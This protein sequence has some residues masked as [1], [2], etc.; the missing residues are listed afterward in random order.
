MNRWTEKAHFSQL[1]TEVKNY[2][3]MDKKGDM[4][5]VKRLSKFQCKCLN[6][7]LLINL[8]FK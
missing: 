5:L 3:E 4:L 1:N 8:L 2:E 7:N 6:V